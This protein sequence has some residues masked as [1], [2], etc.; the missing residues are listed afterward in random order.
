MKLNEYMAN[1]FP[2]LELR[3]A[4]FYSWDIGIRFELGVNYDSDNV[5]YNCPYLIGV[6]HRAITLFNTLHLPDDDLYVVVDVDDFA[7]STAFEKRYNVFSKYVKQKS[8]LYTL[9][10]ITL[11]YI[12]PVDNEDR[13]YKTH[14]FY[15]KCKTA[16]IKYIQM[17]KAI[18]NQDMGMKPNIFHR[19]YFINIRTN[20]I[21]HI[22]DDR[23]C[24]VIAV[25]PKTIEHVYKGYNDWILDYDRAE[26]EKVF[27]RE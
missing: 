23:G 10:Q 24:D 13:D 25:K 7:D 27:N 16:D 5:Y 6:Y 14:R 22:Y 12:Y 1:T 18:C 9:Q 20:T 2:N 4:L 17:I 15:L 11:P 26:I 3:P 19:I 8:K 21:F